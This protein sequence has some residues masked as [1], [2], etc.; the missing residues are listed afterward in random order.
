MAALVDVMEEEVLRALGDGASD[1]GRAARGRDLGEAL[2]RLDDAHV[3]G[4]PAP[5]HLVAA[6]GAAAGRLALAVVE[7]LPGRDPVDGTLQARVVEQAEAGE[8]ENH[9]AGEAGDDPA[10]QA[11][12]GLLA[13]PDGEAARRGLLESRRMA[14]Q[15]ARTRASAGS[16]PSSASTMSCQTV[17]RYLSM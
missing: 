5:A 10:R 14:S 1:G 6:V 9:V 17:P 3:A 13:G 4:V 15:A 16:A 12:A 7:A 2:E 11:A 8:A